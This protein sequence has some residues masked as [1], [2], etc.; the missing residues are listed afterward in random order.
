MWS[1]LGRFRRTRLPKGIADKDV[2]AGRLLCDTY[3]VSIA[4]DL[5]FIYIPIIY[6][7]YYTSFV[8]SLLNTIII[9]G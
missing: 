9:L 8:Y 4:T 5:M 7:L 6:K 2:A 1:K 3:K